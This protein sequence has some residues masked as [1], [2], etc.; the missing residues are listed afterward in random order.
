M[1]D[2]RAEV[3]SDS[4]SA[5]S[6]RW[7]S[8][9]AYWWRRSARYPV[10]ACR[11]AANSRAIPKSRSGFAVACAAGIT[12]VRQSV[13]ATTRAEW[14]VPNSADISPRKA[15]GSETRLTSTPPTSMPTVPSTST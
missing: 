8:E 4:T 15:P 7:V 3:S 12:L 11:R 2:G 10:M 6:P 14:A 9:S 13:S 1:P 5:I